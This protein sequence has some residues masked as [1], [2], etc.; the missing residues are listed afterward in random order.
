MVAFHC[1]AMCYESLNKIGKERHTY[2]IIVVG[3]F[4]TKINLLT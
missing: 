1:T 4:I 3:L 2:T